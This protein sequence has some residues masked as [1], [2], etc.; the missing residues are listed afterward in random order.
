[1]SQQDGIDWDAAFANAPHIAHA[2]EYPARW[3]TRAA[4]YRARHAPREIAYGT[5]PRMRY[6]LFRPEGKPQGLV[7]FVH[8][9]FWLRFDKSFWSHLAAGAASKGWA[10]AIP[11]YVLAPEARIPEMTVQIAA[12]IAHAAHEVVGPIRLVGHSAGGH[13]VTRMICG[14]LPDAILAR[15]AHVQTVSGLHD[16]RPLCN[17]AMNA[18]LHL[19]E[20]GAQAESPAQLRPS[21]GPTVTA[22]VGELERPEFLRQSALLREAWAAQGVAVR[23]CLEP[24][25]H[26]FNVL[27]GLADASA[28][29]CRQ[30]L[31]H[32]G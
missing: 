5:H 18:Q 32:T 24:G 6:D 22:W 3:A 19:D 30:V 20:A 28:L 13:L 23:L 17:T 31:G 2:G 10:V 4:V 27:D 12:A 25:V 9:G 14:A 7:V 15:V 1:M 26:H 11:S 8:G 21:A 16:L 29:L